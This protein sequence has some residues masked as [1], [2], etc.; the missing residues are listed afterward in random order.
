MLKSFQMPMKFLSKVQIKPQGSPRTKRLRNRK[1]LRIMTC[2]KIPIRS[3]PQMTCLLILD[4]ASYPK[5]MT[6]CSITIDIKMSTISRFKKR[7]R[8]K[9]TGEKRLGNSKFKCTSLIIRCRVK[10]KK[11]NQTKSLKSVKILLRPISKLKTS[12]PV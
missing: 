9:K 10:T 8:R 3:I 5:E 6:T 12:Q 1:G 11:K 4:H 2:R 7:R